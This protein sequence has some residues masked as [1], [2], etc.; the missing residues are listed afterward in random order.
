MGKESRKSQSG[1]GDE[2]TEPKT[3]RLSL[4]ITQT[5]RDN[6]AAL[7]EQQN[8]S[9]TEAFERFVRVVSI[10]DLQKA[11]ALK[12]LTLPQLISAVREELTRGTIESLLEIIELAGL[13][14]TL[15]KSKSGNI[16]LQRLNW[17]EKKDGGLVPAKKTIKQLVQENL[18]R[19]IDEIQFPG[20]FK[21][22]R[23]RAIAQGE[24]P[25]YE[26][27]E[28]L[29]F[30]LDMGLDELETQWR[31]EYPNGSTANHIENSRS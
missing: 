16:W 4:K 19:L 15:L 6:L 13:A 5:A 31:A 20:F 28:P 18:Q 9:M 21:E 10:E 22:S 2:W 8:I 3:V 11:E 25:T 12:P 23:L 17:T 14:I 30:L 26:E 29:A 7:A 24:K 27:L 1:Q